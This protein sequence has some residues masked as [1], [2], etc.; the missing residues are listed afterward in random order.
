GSPPELRFTLRDDN[1]TVVVDNVPLVSSA[2]S[3]YGW[4]ENE[5]ISFTLVGGHRYVSYL[6]APGGDPSANYYELAVPNTD[7]S[8]SPWEDL[9]YDGTNSFAAASGNGG[10]SWTAFANADAIF[11]FTEDLTRYKPSGYLL[12]NWY[13]SGSTETQWGTITFNYNKPDGTN[14]QVSVQVDNSNTGAWSST[15]GPF[16]AGD[17][18]E[19]VG[20]TGQYIRYRVELSTTDNTVTPR[21]DDI[22][23]SWTKPSGGVG[24]VIFRVGSP[25]NDNI[26]YDG[27]TSGNFNVLYYDGSSWT[28]RDKQP[29]FV[30]DVDTNSNGVVDAHEG[31]P[32]DENSVY[33]IYDTRY[34]GVTFTISGDIFDNNKV[35]RGFRAYMRKIGT[36]PSLYYTIYDITSG[37]T[38]DSKQI[39]STVTGSWSWVSV[40]T[41]N[42]LIDGHQYRIYLWTT[43]GDTSNCYQWLAPGRTVSYLSG[44]TDRAT[45]DGTNTHAIS[46]ATAGAGWTDN[47]RRDPVFKL[48]LAENYYTSGVLESSVF[49][50]GSVVDWK[51]IQVSAVLSGGTLK[52]YVRTGGDSNPYGDTEN[53]STWKEVTTYIN[54]TA[55]YIQYKLELQAPDN[56]TT[57]VVRWVT[58]NY[59]P[60]P[61]A[62]TVPPDPEVLLRTWIQTTRE[63]FAAG[64]SVEEIGTNIELVAPGDITLKATNYWGNRFES[65][66]GYTP[67]AKIDSRTKLFSIRFQP[68]QTENLVRVRFLS[69]LTEKGETIAP[70]DSPGSWD[71]N[72]WMRVR[73][74][75]D[76][77]TGKP[78]MS[79]APLA[80]GV[81][82]P[83]KEWPSEWYLP[84]PRVGS[85]PSRVGL[86]IVFSDNTW[87]HLFP[88]GDAYVDNDD[89]KDKYNT[90]YGSS[91]SLK[92]CYNLKYD[93]IQRSYLKFDLSQLPAK[94]ITSAKLLLTAKDVGDVD[95]NG[96]GVPMEVYSVTDDTWLED[97]ITWN[98]AP[99]LD[100]LLTE[101]VVADEGAFTWDVTSFIQSEF[102]GDNVASL[103]LRLT[104]ESVAEE[105]EFYSRESGTGG[106][107]GIELYPIVELE[108]G[109][110]YHLVVDA[111]PETTGFISAENYFIMLAL[112]PIHDNWINNRDVNVNR[113]VLFSSDNGKTWSD[114]SDPG[115]VVYNR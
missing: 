70:G 13:D 48:V 103:A 34:A 16:T 97:T 32:Y 56:T 22:S 28:A 107:T 37:T 94:S 110:T 93:S 33:S 14:I 67:R 35:L 47:T 66:S 54:D 62:E 46:S 100:T 65:E 19:S 90:N 80:Y 59:Q 21:F 102:S 89:Y 20:Q 30:L 11:R 42:L 115:S 17:G 81:G 86:R 95:T 64:R 75:P 1:G 18:S 68:E 78:D 2:G 76:D 98:N 71:E 109:Q 61:P 12:S 58:L 84:Y 10:S 49:D 52:K 73:L 51:S 27:R 99:A 26:P 50:A 41:E 57:P 88:S 77:G 7:N 92:V 31:V 63:D 40:S 5:N 114:S 8:G 9:T 69:Q 72:S 6:S 108:S 83:D 79:G 55:R 96:P 60:P 24:W 85:R 104:G 45:F 25:L 44:R 15:A 82:Y 38:V 87:V 74:F 39:T 23:I 113:G 53:W 43:G 112:K 106:F 111:N 36:P 3:S 101:T 105:A 29:I 4:V 91:T